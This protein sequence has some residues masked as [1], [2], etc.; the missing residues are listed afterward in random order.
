M[1]K[2]QI[3]KKKQRIFCLI[4]KKQDYYWHFLDITKN[5]PYWKNKN[6]HNCLHFNKDKI[7]VRCLELQRIVEIHAAY[8]PVPTVGLRYAAL[9]CDD[10]KHISKKRMEDYLKGVELFD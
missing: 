7:K 4:E 8:T 2:P 5:D 1:K 10:Y 6:C 3:K 9:I